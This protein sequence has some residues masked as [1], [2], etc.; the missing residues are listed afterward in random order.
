MIR[1]T[2]GTGGR[3]GRPSAAARRATPLPRRGL[4][5]DATAAGALRST[6]R[7]DRHRAAA[8]LAIAAADAGT[9]VPTSVRIEAGWDRR[10]PAW[11]GAD[12]LVPRDDALDTEVADLA[13]GT[14]DPTQAPAPDR[15]VDGSGR[16]RRPSVVDRHVAV[17]AH[18]Q[19]RRPDIAVV[20]VLTSDAQDIGTMLARLPTPEHPVDVHALGPTR[21]PSRGP[22]RRS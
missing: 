3:R 21:A 11:S 9:V 12:R 8:I 1:G 20:E 10:S 4:V 2:T 7:E 6:Q 15:G 13:T 5:L 14:L 17:A 16:S 19:A 22:S 18:R